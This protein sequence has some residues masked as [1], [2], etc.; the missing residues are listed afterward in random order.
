MFNAIGESEMELELEA[1]GE[2]EDE[3]ESELED[4]YES[5][6]EDEYE[7]EYEDEYEDELEGEAEDEYEYESE[8]E[9][10]GEGPNPVN[11]IYP[12]AMMEHLGVAAM[13]AETEDEAAEHF[14][15]LV[16]LAASK[17]LP[18]AAKALPKLAGKVLPKI[19]RVVTRANPHMTRAVGHLARQLHR[20]PRTR[21][22]VRA[23]PSVARRA[24]TTI[25]R[26]TAA[27]HPVSPRHAVRIL[28]K[29]HRRV[30][31][32]PAILRSV[33]RR[34][35]K[36][37]RKAHPLGLGHRGHGGGMRYLRHR[38]HLGR[39]GYPLARG[40]R[41]LSRTG[42]GGGKIGGHRRLGGS[43]CPTCGARR[44]HGVRR[45]CCCC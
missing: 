17:L 32:N 20:N 1:L 6:L 25:A 18:L 35:R 14:L 24:I 42:L 44:T 7:G 27:G 38:G 30:M 36:L 33:M 4:E 16:S 29:E 41:G 22:L 43:V 2:A 11:K 10:E 15:P 12:D 34:S 5:E 9:L 28:G 39:H 21:A 45:T 13:E 37:E 23:I 19:A 31:R 3:F 8:Y 26:R 40:V